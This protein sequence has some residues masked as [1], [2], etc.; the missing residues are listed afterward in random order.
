MERGALQMSALYSK[1]LNTAA[2][3]FPAMGTYCQPEQKG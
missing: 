1:P 3:L 2:F